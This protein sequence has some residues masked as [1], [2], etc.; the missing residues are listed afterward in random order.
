M[1]NC[2]FY[3]LTKKWIKHWIFSSTCINLFIAT[4]TV[5][6]LAQASKAYYSS[7]SSWYSLCSSIPSWRFAFAVSAPAL[8]MKLQKTMRISTMNRFFRFL[9]IKHFIK[10]LEWFEDLE[11]CS[12]Q[13]VCVRHFL[14]NNCGISRFQSRCR[15]LHIAPTFNSFSG[16]PK[17]R[18]QALVRTCA[19][20]SSLE[21]LAEIGD[22]VEAGASKH[23]HCANARWL[24]F[25]DFFCGH[26]N[27]CVALHL[28]QA[29]CHSN[30]PTMI[31]GGK[32]Q[33]RNGQFYVP[34]KLCGL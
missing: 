26:S 20:W 4:F 19:G 28:S 32:I 8:K 6:I 24:D 3:K 14:A 7:S 22:I 31:H 21:T 15:L 29:L 17:A 13:N 18:S 16:V 11:S 25:G 2:H 10:M 23:V 5:A 30:V 9:R 1:E 33:F 27:S 34:K 12:L